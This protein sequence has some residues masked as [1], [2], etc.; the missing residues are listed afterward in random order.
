M[1]ILML[2]GYAQT[3]DTFRRK[4]R[5][6]ETGLRQIDAKA[7]FVYLDGPI[8]LETHDIP[9]S[10]A[11]YHHKGEHDMRAWFDLRIVRNPP[12]GI[13]RS[14]DL[15]AAVLKNQG[16]FDGIV[17]FSQGTVVGAMVASLLQGDVRRRAYEA[18]L[19]Q[20]DDILD[21]P[22]SFLDIRH[23]PLKFALFYASRVG[24]G[25]YSG[26]MYQYPRIETPFCHFYGKW[27]P[28]VSYEERDAV[29]DR[30]R[31]DE[32]AIVVAH[33]GG[34]FVPTDCQSIEAACGFVRRCMLDACQ[35]SRKDSG[36]SLV[37]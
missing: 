36:V 24:T 5:R 18:A 35:G 12:T 29:L 16:P 8:K 23:P 6:L 22:E 31:G 26:W 1:K 4:V 20:L 19:E 21:Y 3:G 32:E 25:D 17:A 2:H 33:G 27:D 13:H 14:L 11:A 10:T 37:V 30:V 7:E 15:L 34:H 28:M 9:G